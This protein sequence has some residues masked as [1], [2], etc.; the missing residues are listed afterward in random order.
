[1]VKNYT[2]AA[3]LLIREIRAPTCRGGKVNSDFADHVRNFVLAKL[4]LESVASIFRLLAPSS[5]LP[6]LRRSGYAQA[7]G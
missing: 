1:M 6:C 5:A 2:E 7:G 4:V 3:K